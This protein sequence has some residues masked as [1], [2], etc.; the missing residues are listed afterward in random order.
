MKGSVSLLVI[1]LSLLSASS[2]RAQWVRAVPTIPPTQEEDA[3]PPDLMPPLRERALLVPVQPWDD[4]LEKIEELERAGR[5]DKVLGGTLIGIGTA[6]AL[7]STAF[8]LRG[9][10]WGGGCDSAP[11]RDSHGD[12]P[13]TGAWT[14][15]AIVG[16]SLLVPGVSLYTDGK[17]ATDHAARLQGMM[18]RF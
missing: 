13:D 15:L 14:T 17:A 10:L 12:T 9:N 7:I 2:V 16:I 18:L 3:P 8:L 4:P 11:H 5:N 1:L 6:L